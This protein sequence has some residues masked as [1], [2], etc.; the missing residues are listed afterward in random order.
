MSKIQ[1]WNDDYVAFGFTKV[2]RN[3]LDCAQC[4]HC[5]YVM[6]NASLRPYKLANHRDKKHPQMKSADIGT[7]TAKR[8]QYDRE[9][10]ITHFGFLQEEKPALQCSYEVAY[11]IAKCKSCTLLR[12]TL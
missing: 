1:K 3:G 11:R 10:S 7:M 4:L 2:N 5:S 9:A 12:K 6:S 8:A